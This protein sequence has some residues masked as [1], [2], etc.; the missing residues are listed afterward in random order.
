MNWT[1]AFWIIEVMGIL[2]AIRAIYYAP[3]AS[4]AIAW[5]L[6]L[7]TFPFISLPFYWLLSTRN[8]HSYAKLRRKKNTSFRKQ[9]DKYSAVRKE[10]D[11]TSD[12]DER[13]RL[14][15]NIAGS[16]VLSNNYMELLINGSQSYEK[17]FSKIREAKK[18]V[19]AQFFIIENDKVAESFV[20]LLCQK[21]REGVDTF[22]LYD[23][24]GTSDFK[25]SWH[26][27]L[28][29]SGV[30]IGVFAVMKSTFNPYQINFRNHRKL[31]IVDGSDCFLGGMNIGKSYLGLSKNKK[32]GP[33]RD[34]M[35]HMKGPSVLECQTLFYEDWYW[36]T[37]EIPALPWKV[38]SHELDNVRSLILGTGPADKFQIMGPTIM[39]L[40]NSAKKRLWLTTPYFIP[41]DRVMGALKLAVKRGVDVRLLF[42]K[43][44]DHLFVWLA[45][46]V[47]LY[48]IVSEGV[49]V[50]FYTD[51]FMHQKVM[52][53]DDDLCMTG[54]ANL[55]SR[56]LFLN[57]EVS[58]IC[59]D[60][61]F[62]SKMEVM[63]MQDF[64]KSE[65]MQPDHF[66]NTSILFQFGCRFSYLFSSVL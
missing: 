20:E 14:F 35:V 21:A 28:S 8:F 23:A 48:N 43:N 33:W 18:Y 55:D 49:G 51:G 26:R 47:Y 37:D 5:A 17:M 46:Q 58:V 4:S 12:C 2:S 52:L 30:R 32:L 66:E 6:S 41:D 36:A 63:L 62:A 61:V 34:T 31:L 53:I 10:Y 7:V 19:L 13:M 29:K 54:S 38:T 22:L 65:Q 11:V 50:Y 9:Y 57:F 40:I 60:Q 42:P 24:I 15:S 45:S 16:P 64:K 25:K 27:K 44:Y 3:N 1:I 56:S 39:A 59:L